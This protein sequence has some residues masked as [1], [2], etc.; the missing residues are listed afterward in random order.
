MC[1]FDW[2]KKKKRNKKKETKK[3]N[4]KKKEKK[5]QKKKETKILI[6]HMGTPWR[7]QLLVISIG[8]TIGSPNDRSSIP[9]EI[10]T[11]LW[12]SQGA[13]VLQTNTAYCILILRFVPETASGQGWPWS[14]QGKV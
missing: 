7:S 2:C 9:L 12:D 3:R 13:A 10:G 8:D 1:V 14:S 11:K 4:K 5:K 6:Y